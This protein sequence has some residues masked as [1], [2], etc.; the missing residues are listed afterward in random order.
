MRFII[1]LPQEELESVERICFQVEEG[2]WYYEDFIRPLDPDLPSLNLRNFCLRIFQHCPLLS[3]FSPYHHAT[4]FEEFLAYKTRVPV[5]GAIMLNQ[6]MDQVILVKGWKKGANWSFPRGKINKDESDLACAIREV[7]EETGYDVEA[8][9]LVGPQAEMKYIDVVIQHQHLRLYVF[10]GVPMDTQFEAKTRKEISKIDWWKLSELP[11]LKKKKQ[12]QEGRGEDLALNANKFYMV[13][14]FLVP[15]KKWISQQKRLMK[16]D[17]MDQVLHPIEDENEQLPL[18]IDGVKGDRGNSTS[19]DMSRL[20]AGLRQPPQEPNSE[21]VPTFITTSSADEASLQ[22]KTLLRVSTEQSTEVNAPSPAQE[23][24][25]STLLALL[26]GEKPKTQHVEPQTPLELATD[27]SAV[28]ESPKP[29]HMMKPRLAAL[30]RPPVFQF[31]RNR[32]DQKPINQSIM[33]NTKVAKTLAPQDQQAS[34]MAWKSFETT[35]AEQEAERK[36]L[37]SEKQAD[38]LA[39]E[40]QTG[41]R[42]KPR[43]PVMSETWRQVKVHDVSSMHQARQRQVVNVLERPVGDLA[44]SQ[45]V[46]EYRQAQQR[47]TFDSAFQPTAAPYQ[48]TSNVEPSDKSQYQDIYRPTIPAANKLPMPKL[49]SHSSSLL[50]LFKKGPTRKDES[51]LEPV[52]GSS[53]P[54]IRLPTDRNAMV[55]GEIGEQQ[56]YVS[57]DRRRSELFSAPPST[58]QSTVQKTS[59]SKVPQSAHQASLL[60]LFRRPLVP[61]DATTQP[62]QVTL[63]VPVDIVELSAMPSPSRSKHIAKANSGGRQR[64]SSMQIGEP[65]HPRKKVV[66][67]S[68]PPVSATV[69]GPLNVPQF[70]MIARRADT[71]SIQKSSPVREVKKSPV[72]I[73]AR[74]S[75][76]K[77]N[78]QIG[79]PESL[80]RDGQYGKAPVPPSAGLNGNNNNQPQNFQPKILRRPPPSAENPAI[81]PPGSAQSS[82]HLSN[83]ERDPATPLASSDQQSTMK[84]EHKATLLSLFTNT[85]SS[86]P[87]PSSQYISRPDFS[88][89]VSPIATQPPNS[90]PLLSERLS[91]N[92]NAAI[93]SPGNMLP[94]SYKGPEALPSSVG[95]SRINSWERQTPAKKV[96]NDV[97]RNFLLGYLDGVAKKEGR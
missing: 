44:E 91:S 40:E 71:S 90:F 35:S 26:R 96:T 17:S 34:I 45:D 36:R 14:P 39:R 11:T 8:A 66:N 74:P 62:S 67:H 83:G 41:V 75:T 79:L 21:P 52:S 23:S 25:A 5:R 4:A 65:N 30:P 84:P 76:A 1:N 2:Q 61:A 32:D 93:P 50:D 57:G 12:H 80:I 20:L 43:L 15:L 22:L 78:E 28:P 33:P 82:T 29:Q 87:S 16:L 73:L 53:T 9:G 81:P 48:V 72:T 70:E 37:L 38:Q 6:A 89:F 86:L 95:T 58:L 51:V 60:E 92:V 27:S 19:E 55:D 49:T 31:D 63:D 94:P 85:K 97:D 3:E 64:K 77:A 24:D 47:A 46:T 69:N 10:P 13:A 56:P 18:D 88:A 59:D 42:N 68:N 7:Y 54:A